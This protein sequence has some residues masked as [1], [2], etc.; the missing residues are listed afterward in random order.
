MYILNGVLGAA[1]GGRWQVV[2]D[3]TRL[4]LNRGHSVLMLVN[5][6]R[7]PDPAAVPS[8]VAL[9]HVAN[10]GHYD[11]LAAW[12]L[13]RRFRAS[14]PDI[15]LAHCSRSVALLKRALPA[16]V[17]VVAVSHSPKVCRLLPADACLALNADIG[18]RFS[19]A[20]GGKPHF[21]IP[22]MIPVATARPPQWRPHQPPRFA[23]MGRFDPVKGFDVFIDA[24]GLLKQRG[25]LFEAWLAGDGDERA[26]LEARA[27]ACAVADRLHFPGWVDDIEGFLAG[28]DILCVPARSDAFGLTPLPAA[29]AGVPM[30]LSANSGHRGIF[31]PEEQALFAQVGDAK[32]TADQ[33]ARLAEQPALAL[34]LREAAFATLYQHY[35]TQVVAGRLME[36]IE[37]KIKK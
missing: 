31:A 23:A 33:L 21:V 12:R 3:Y 25:Y 26:R 30:V 2:C 9:A 35:S 13:S 16:S 1:D 7:R 22:N 11:F 14:P 18:A 4:F 29:R 34:K 36:L 37:S 19:V 24:L 15:A 20:S 27:A 28:V 5:A 8:G 6:R 10:H 32:G 17:P